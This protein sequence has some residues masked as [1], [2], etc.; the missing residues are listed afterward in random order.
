MG[1]LR[2]FGYEISRL[3]RDPNEKLPGDV[4]PGVNE[5][6][7]KMFRGENPIRQRMLMRLAAAG[8]AVL[9]IA[10]AVVQPEIRGLTLLFGFGISVWCWWQSML[11][12][13]AV[14][15]DD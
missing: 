14:D 13:R 12:D 9:T 10:M 1:M 5:Q 2:D 3:R 6:G 15:Y 4:R 11:A 7:K 8:M